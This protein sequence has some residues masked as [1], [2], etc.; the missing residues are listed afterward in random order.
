MFSEIVLALWSCTGLTWWMLAARLSAE[1]QGESGEVPDSPARRTLSVFKPLPPLGASGLKVVAEGIESF[2]AQLDPESELLLGIHEVDRDFT[3][4]FLDRLRTQYPK[5][6]LK[7]VFRF[8][9]DSVANPKIAWQKILAQQAEGELWL[10][11]DADVIAPTGF[12]QSARNEYARCGA[13]MVTF[14]YVIRKIPAPAALLEALFVNVEFY[15]GVLLLRKFGPV[16]FGLG[17]AMVFQ[18]D[19][20]LRQVDWNEIGATLADDFF[21]GQKLGPVRIGTTTLATVPGSFTWKQALA[22]DLRWAKTIRWNRPA[23]SFARIMVMPVPGWLIAAALHPTHFFIWIGLVG[24]IQA[25]VFFAAAICRNAGCQLKPGQIPGL[26]AWSLWRIL[27]WFLCWLPW[28]VLWSEK[29]WR[30]PRS[31]LTV[32]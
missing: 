8:E 3:E 26:E 23:G 14:P 10:W 30:G 4:P 5:T 29:K 9:P 28:P 31:N 22:H 18:R 32:N 2:V 24:M 13:A 19:D 25:D 12:L 16:D 21:L 20:F 6:R 17:A 1:D 27:L 11:S 7:V 15:P